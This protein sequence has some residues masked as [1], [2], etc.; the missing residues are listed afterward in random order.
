MV[1]PFKWFQRRPQ[2]QRSFAVATAGD[3]RLRDPRLLLTA[4]NFYVGLRREERLSI[5]YAVSK[6]QPLAVG[7]L[8][9]ICRFVNSRP[10][11]KSGDP[12]VD[13]RAKEIWAEIKGDEVN[14]QLIRQGNTYGYAVGEIVFPSGEIERVVVPESPTIRFVADA[15]GQLQGAQQL[16]GTILV[17]GS[18]KSTI[19][20]EKL[21]VWQRDKTSFTDY[22]G[23]SLFESVT[24]QLEQICQVMNA[25]ISVVLRAGKPRFLVTVDAANLTPEQLEDRLDKATE[26]LSSLA[27]NEATDLGLP[28]GCE[29]KIIGAESYG[30]KFQLEVQQILQ[31]FLAGVG[32]PPALLSLVTQSSA[33]TE[34]WLRQVILCLQTMIFSQQDAIATAWNSSFWKLVQQLEGMPV[35]PQMEFESARLLE[36]LQ[37]EQ[38]RAA[39]WTNDLQECRAKIRPPQWL[40]QQCGADSAYD[41]AGLEEF[42][43]SA[44]ETKDIGSEATNKSSLTK[45]TDERATNNKQM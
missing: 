17:P 9:V 21:I 32:L 39:K 1:N 33:G 35:A 43:E 14:S 45:G 16:A 11:F 31:N 15:M 44:E 40:A 13:R 20:I 41:L 28:G 6:S 34:S 30:V 25:F 24:D 2:Q 37:E 4:A 27:S 19:P 5:Y 42:I 7:A 12:D 3:Q 18:A 38:A 22:Y 8:N 10:I 23:T 26:A 29:I 36:M